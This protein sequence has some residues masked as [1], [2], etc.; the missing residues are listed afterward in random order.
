MSNLTLYSVG[1]ILLLHHRQQD[2]RELKLREVSYLLA[3]GI[4]PVLLNYPYPALIT[5]L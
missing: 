4:F 1:H 2:E 3:I 5:L